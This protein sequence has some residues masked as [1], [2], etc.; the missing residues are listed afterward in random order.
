M[1][2]TLDQAAL[3]RTLFPLGELPKS[4]TRRIAADLGLPVAEKPD[5]AD[6]CF[7]P[8]GD[9]R[10]LLR[11]RGVEPR[12]GAIVTVAGDEVGRHDGVAAYTVGQRRGAG[13]ARAA[14]PLRHRRRR[15]DERRHGGRRRRAGATRP[16]RLAAALGGGGRRRPASGSACACATTSRRRRAT[17]TA[18]D[19]D[20]FRVQFERPVRAVAPGQ[21]AVL[22][23]DDE[24]VGGGTIEP[25]AGGAIV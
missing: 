5:S 18:L 15:R 21:A 10:A 11:E 13:A 17:V 4:E 25:P 23:R 19:G 16:R 24:V 8:A 22:Y 2:Y 3:A 20:S 6:I 7:V 9:Y 14:A 12:P 1:L